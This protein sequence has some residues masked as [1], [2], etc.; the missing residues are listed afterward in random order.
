MNKT[1]L[2]NCPRCG[3]RFVRQNQSHSCKPFPLE[4][5][6]EGKP[7][8]K[9]LYEKLKTA[10]RNRLGTFHIQSLECCIH[11]DHLITFAAVKIA[12][13]KLTL[14]FSLDHKLNNKRCSKCVQLSAKRFLHYI[15]IVS[16]DEIDDDLLG[17]V[18]EAYGK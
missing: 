13:D 9:A 17:W 16:A 2:W 15:P 12:K 10:I 6:F 4:K 14:E 1:T 5:H 8:G 7:V 11:F 3:R 18:K